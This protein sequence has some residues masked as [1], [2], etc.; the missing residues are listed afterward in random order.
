MGIVSSK[1]QSLVGNIK[2]FF[3]GGGGGQAGAVSSMMQ[4][5]PLEVNDHPAVS[6]M[7]NNKYSFATAQYPATLGHTDEGHY[8]IFIAIR[9]ETKSEQRH[10]IGDSHL[11]LPGGKAEAAKATGAR[12][13]TNKLDAVDTGQFDNSVMTL[14]GQESGIAAK[15]FQTHSIAESAIFLYTPPGI[16]SNYGI[17]YG[18]VEM[19]FLGTAIKGGTSLIKDFSLKDLGT[20][21]KLAGGMT[22]DIFKRLGAMILG[23]GGTAAFQKGFGTAVNPHMEVIFESVPM[24]EFTFEYTFAPNDNKELQSTHKIL[25]FFKNYMHPGFQSADTEAQFILPE[26]FEIRYMYKDKENMYLPKISRCVLANMETDYS[27]NEAFTTFKADDFGASPNIIKMTLT[28]KEIE[29]MTKATIS[30]KGSDYL[31][32][33]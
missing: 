20:T 10:K 18:N 27:P 11:G 5:S 2:G 8:M 1:I 21:A 30:P 7:K 13:L 31:G 22:K 25:R 23:E 4:K 24:R 12:N 29:I 15:T 32:G 6:H 28:F 26:Q 9:Q 33:M 3:K 17:N 16:K 14:R 19:G